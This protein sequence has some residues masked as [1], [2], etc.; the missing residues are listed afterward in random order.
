MIICNIEP[1]YLHED[2]N[3]LWS[4]TINFGRKTVQAGLDTISVIWG[5]LVS[6]DF[7][8]LDVV[9]DIWKQN[10]EIVVCQLMKGKII[11]IYFEHGPAPASQRIQLSRRK[12]EEIKL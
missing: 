5:L 7:N 4:K 11:M 8:K 1:E 10:I 3:C 9:F 6:Y 12:R 2:A